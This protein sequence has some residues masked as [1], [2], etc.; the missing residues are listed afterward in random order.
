M[1]NTSDLKITAMLTID[2]VGGLIF[3]SKYY[4]FM[5]QTA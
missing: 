3:I 4:I 5:S 1:N 2:L